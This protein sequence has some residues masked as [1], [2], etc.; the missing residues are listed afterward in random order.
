MLRHYWLKSIIFGLLLAGGFYLTQTMAAAT[1]REFILDWTAKSYVPPTY[2]GKALPVRG[3]QVTVAAIPLKKL[4]ISPDKMYFRWL[5]DGKA[6]NYAKGQ[7]QYSLTFIVKKWPGDFHEVEMQVTNAADKL[8]D[9]YR[10][11]VPV[12]APEIILK[13]DNGLAAAG[14][15]LASTG[16]TINLQALPFF[17][18]ITRPAQELTFNWFFEEELLANPG[19]SDPDRLTVIIPQGEL[20]EILTKAIRLTIKNKTNADQQ[21]SVNLTLKIR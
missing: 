13:K 16:Q 10:I 6:Q 12:V 19:Q 17:F 8:L 18:S 7:G 4:A 11:Y 5:L 1:E 15:T 2:Q 14:E 3:G 20:S 21:N 9:S